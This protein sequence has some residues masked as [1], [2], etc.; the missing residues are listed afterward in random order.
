MKTASTPFTN[1]ASVLLRVLRNRSYDLCFATRRNCAVSE[2]ENPCLLLACTE[3][4]TESIYIYIYIHGAAAKIT[5]TATTQKK[6]KTELRVAAAAAWSSLMW[7]TWLKRCETVA[8]GSACHVKSRCCHGS[9]CS[10]ETKRHKKE[11]KHCC[12]QKIP[13]VRH[14]HAACVFGMSSRDA[15]DNRGGNIVIYFSLSI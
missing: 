1:V 11:K 10:R 13:P 15:A 9:A 14:P 5:F 7:A 12:R 6:R 3:Y 8:L 4:N 2:L